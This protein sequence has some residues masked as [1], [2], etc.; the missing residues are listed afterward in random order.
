[1]DDHTMV[2]VDISGVYALLNISMWAVICGDIN[3][4][5]KI[6]PVF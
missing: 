1:M 6:V 5:G 2:T 3:V 4:K